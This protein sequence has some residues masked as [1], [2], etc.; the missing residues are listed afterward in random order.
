MHKE[1]A[2]EKASADY[3]LKL[4]VAGDAPNSRLA[5]ENLRRLQ[6]QAPDAVFDIKVV[7]VLESPQEALKAGVYVTPALQVIRPAPQTMIFGNLTD[8]KATQTLFANKVK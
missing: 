5:R 4:F 6:A 7:D 8:N 3:V 1:N 2:P